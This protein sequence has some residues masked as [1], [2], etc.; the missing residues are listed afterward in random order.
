MDYYS[1]IYPHS[2][3]YGGVIIQT[4]WTSYEQLKNLN[5]GH[6]FSGVLFHQDKPHESNTEGERNQYPGNIQI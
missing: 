5:L 2:L 3:P 6:R 1:W 4:R